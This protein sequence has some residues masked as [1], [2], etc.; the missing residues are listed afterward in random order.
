MIKIEDVTKVYMMGEVEVHAL[1]GVS[2]EI[3]EG[4]WLSIMGPSGSGKSTLMNLI[5]CLDTATEGFYELNGTDV[6]S[7]SE[8]ELANIRNRE[9]GFVFQTFNLLP[10]LTAAQNVELPPALTGGGVAYV[11]WAYLNTSLVYGCSDVVNTAACRPSRERLARATA[12]SSSV[13]D[14]IGTTGPKDSS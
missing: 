3:M 9:I 12:S 10:R 8:D 2:L 11:S 14:R 4:E 1:R 13:A 6:G 5:G 7:L